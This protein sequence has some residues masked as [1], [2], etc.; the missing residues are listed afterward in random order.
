MSNEIKQL[1]LSHQIE[2]TNLK[3]RITQQEQQYFQNH[4]VKMK[5]LKREHADM[6]TKLSDIKD[7]YDFRE[8]QTEILQ[9]RIDTLQDKVL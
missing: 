3:D 9:S 8:K 2:V 6:S 7:K 4:V 5:K 1:T